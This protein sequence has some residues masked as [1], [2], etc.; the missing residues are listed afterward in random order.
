M[1]M[2]EK[3]E[4]LKNTIV[5]KTIINATHIIEKL[6]SPDGGIFPD[7]AKKIIPDSRLTLPIKV[8]NA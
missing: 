8:I 4:M 6:K 7:E 5:I 1:C 3:K 2:S